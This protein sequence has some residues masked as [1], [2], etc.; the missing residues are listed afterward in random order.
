MIKIIFLDID[1]VLN[2]QQ[3]FFDKSDQVETKSGILS[4][5]SVL[6]LNKITDKTGSKIVVTSTWR[7]DGPNVYEALI[8]GGI[9]GDIIG[10][11]GSGC[12][13]CVRGN[14]ILD[15]IKSNDNLVGNYSDYKSYV[16][17]D[18]DSDMLYWQRNNF[19]CVDYTV[20][21]TEKTVYQVCRFLGEKND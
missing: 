13:C 12:R 2:H 14:E 7:A 21:I 9:T 10:M 1:G 6:L 19:F 18:D 11:T 20:G 17:L 8:S 4:K 16:I 15:W 3:M 5:K